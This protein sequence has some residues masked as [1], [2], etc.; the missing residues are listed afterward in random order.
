[1]GTGFID[2]LS[3]RGRLSRL[4][5][6]ALFRPVL[7]FAEKHDENGYM[8]SYCQELL[9]GELAKRKA[10]NSQYSV[11]AFAR[12]LGIS[13]TA[14]SDVLSL[15]RELSRKNIL[16]AAEYLGWSPQQK[17]RVMDELRGVEASDTLDEKLE[18]EED[19]FRLIS[20]WFYFGILNLAKLE[21]NQADPKWI[22]KRL[23]ISMVEASDALLRLKRLG[24]LETENGRLRRTAAPI[25]TTQDIPS[26]AL[27][28]YHRQNLKKSEEALDEIEVHL[29][30]VSAITLALDPSRMSEAKHVIQQFRRKLAKTFD[31]A[32]KPSEVYTLAIQFFPITREE[33]RRK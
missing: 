26:A 18:L 11:R 29:R 10:R 19:T 22:A 8:E 17:K 6:D 23:G 14:L 13:N 21:K 7:L 2:V 32:G 30:E 15:R 3:R 16:I 12:D 4:S 5:R 24:Y 20:D 27:R 9:R 28:N 33:S 25:R 31:A 1:M